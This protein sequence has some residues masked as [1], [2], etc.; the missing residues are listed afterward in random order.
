MR[1][2]TFVKPGQALE[3]WEVPEPQLQGPGEALVRPVAV[4]SCDLDS[5]L[6]HGGTPWHGPF[7]FGHEF[8]AEVVEVGE[9][10]S[11]FK[12]GQLVI[13]PFQISC[14]KCA[15]CLQGLTGS[16][17]TVKAGAMYGLAPLGGEWGGALS[18]LVR[19]PF[20]EAMLVTVPVGLSPT[21]LA[22]TSDNMPDAWR[23]VGPQLEKRPGAPVL[24]V[25]GAAAGSIGLYA[26]AIALALGASKV[27]YVDGD[28]ARLEVASKLG[29]NPLEVKAAF[30]R[31]FG[32]Y[33]ITVDAGSNPEGLVSA[34]RS[35]EPGGVCTSAAIYF[36][37]VTLPLLEMYTAGVTFQTSR[38][39]SRPTIPKI[40]EL[41]QSGR[42]QPDLITSDRASWDEA[43]EAFLHY[44]TKLVVSR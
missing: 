15:R 14:G 29:A 40:F 28:T 30:P 9:E 6:V 31:R 12:P 1:Q 5:A 18:D 23:T 38:V 4:A 35:T 10:V 26:A 21:T 43:G 13:V 37:P 25:G 34:L 19:V 16:C 44:H 7:A 41:V 22:S 36:Q 20:A 39:M 2:L 17:T 32:V 33:P 27:D 8:V 11:H 42:L 24:I 3:W